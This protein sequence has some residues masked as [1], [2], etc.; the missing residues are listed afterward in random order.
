M[1]CKTALKVQVVQMIHAQKQK[2]AM[3]GDQ[4]RLGLKS[5][6]TSHSIYKQLPGVHT[7]RY[8]SANRAKDR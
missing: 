2:T 1:F 4:P 7:T 8:W 3:P 6:V 5:D